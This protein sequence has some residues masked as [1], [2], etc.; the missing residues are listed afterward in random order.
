MAPAAVAW[1]PYGS[2]EADIRSIECSG[3]R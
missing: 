1:S 3:K 2:V